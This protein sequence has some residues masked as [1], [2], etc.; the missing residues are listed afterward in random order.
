MFLVGLH[1]GRRR[2]LQDITGHLPLIRR[3]L[4]GGLSLGV[5]VNAVRYF[6][7]CAGGDCW[8]SPFAMPYTTHLLVV[9]LR[10]ISNLALAF[11]YGSAFVLLAQRR[12]WHALFAP[13]AAAGRLA[14]TNYLL[15]AL[16]LGIVAPTFGFGV[17]K[18]LGPTLASALAVAIYATLM[19]LSTWWSKRFRFGPAEWLWRSLTYGRLQ[20]IRL[21]P[22]P[23]PAV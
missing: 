14:L 21:R 2:I 3:V 18:R 9:I 19:L 23:A 20:P 11:A 8:P 15:M 16:L 1:A 12:F 5:A 22:S 13:L 10:E 6:L 17:Y 7:T 4:L